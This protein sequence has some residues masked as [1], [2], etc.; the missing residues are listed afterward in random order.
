MAF[1]KFAL[2]M[3]ISLFANALFSKNIDINLQNFKSIHQIQANEFKNIQPS[4]LKSEQ[5]YK[6]YAKGEV[7]TPRV[8]KQVLGYYTYWKTGTA[9]IQ[10]DLLTILA[11][12]SAE[13]DSSGNITDLNGWPSS[14]PIN[15]AHAH[16]VKVILTATLFG[17]DSIRT[18]IQSE[19]N[20]QNCIQ[21]LFNQV[22]SAGADGICIDFELPYSSDRDYFNTFIQELADYFH[23]NMPGSLV[24]VDTPAVNWNDRMDFNTLTDYA[25]YLFIMAYDYHYSGGDPG[26]VSP[27]SYTSGSPWPTWAGIVQ[28]LDDYINGT[29]GVGNAK[30]SKLIL[31]VP[32][33]GYDW[34]A[35]DCTIP[36]TQRANASAV[37][38]SSAVD[39]AAQYN[40]EWDNYSQTP[41]YDYNCST[42][43]P[44]QAWYDDDISLGLKYDKV[45]EYG[46][47]GTGMWA[48]N[49]D[50]TRPELWQKL[51]EKFGFSYITATAYGNGTIS[52]SGKIQVDY[53]KNITFNFSPQAGY[54]I[55]DV[56]VDGTSV[57][58]VNSY[59][60]EN[61]V[62]DHTIEVY[63]EQDTPIT[64]T[65]T[66]TAGTGGTIE[67]SGNITANEGESIS[68]S[69]TPS[70]GY[71]IDRVLVDG[72]NVGA[73]STYTFNNINSNHTI[74]AYFKET[75]PETFTITA[76]A[77][78]GGII[79]PSGGI[80]VTKGENITFSIKPDPGFNID[81]VLIDGVNIGVVNSYTFE[82]VN[83]NHTIEAYFIENQSNV[84]TITASAGTGG[85]IDPSGEVKVGDGEN[86]T[87]VITP[88]TNYRIKEV[89]ID[90]NSVGIVNSYTFNNVQ[91]NHTIEAFFTELSNNKYSIK[92]DCGEGG[93]IFP[94]GELVVN[95]G[96]TKTFRITPD[97]GYIIDKVVVDGTN[98]G[99]LSTYTFKNINAN[100]T[101]YA[102]FTE[103]SV[104]EVEYFSAST[105]TGLTAL[106]VDFS[107]KFNE[108]NNRA[109]TKYY[110]IVSGDYEGS[111]ETEEPN[112]SLI[113]YA[114]G[115]YYIKVEA[116]NELGL[117]GESNFIRILPVELKNYP[118]SINGNYN[119]N[120]R[121]I[122]LNSHIVNP[123]NNTVRA[124]IKKLDGDNIIETKNITIEPY[125]KIK[126][127]DLFNNENN[128]ETYQ[129]TITPNSFVL[130]YTDISSENLGAAAYQGL[131]TEWVLNIPHIA[132]ETNYW[133]TIAS[134]GNKNAKNLIVTV[135]NNGSSIEAKY[136]N[137]INL[138]KLAENTPESFC[139]GTVY[140]IN[141]SQVLN[142][143]ELFVQN[144]ND[145][146]AISLSSKATNKFY[147]PHIPEEK[148]IFWTGFTFSNTENKE[149]KIVFYLYNDSKELIGTKTI[150]IAPLSKVK[151]L[152]EQL[153]DNEELQNAVW[154]YAVSSVKIT[155]IEIY[156]VSGGAICG[157]PL[158]S[159]E[160]EIGI[161]PIAQSD[162]NYWT[163]IIALN[164][165]T[166]NAF[167]T[168]KLYDGKGNEINEKQIKIEPF[169]RYKSLIGDLFPENRINENYFIQYFS[170]KPLICIEVEGDKTRTFMKALNAY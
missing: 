24:V 76:T 100:H 122:T 58:T 52:P 168:F 13:L 53:G 36:T 164:P 125:N 29:Y 65:I 93:S 35:Q 129:Y 147:I 160:K 154:G 105:Q 9:N 79:S 90:G 152:F 18:L 74:E 143:F 22:Q 60:F 109:I 138:N 155:G 121:E 69:I 117:K 64:Y 42:S 132:E 140:D 25:D 78:N 15:E 8:K 43:Y 141:Q 33:Y 170:S 108:P 10:W 134:I 139:W 37:I 47:G 110:W 124:S 2:L 6:L 81:R 38:Y 72:N 130:I 151:G 61:V 31:G 54:H 156:G 116:E 19:T 84:Y 71:A 27:L 66:A 118:L 115:T 123:L 131:T 144:N 127:S 162:E 165:N 114:A 145:G 20:R 82:N 14:A 119:L 17:Y 104:P 146:A 95:E 57:G 92:S 87:F 1:K 51:R 106:T 77:Y 91:A 137:L 40:R 11:Y 159:K 103:V 167:V 39:K 75:Q 21:N 150:D 89:L 158:P 96:E 5:Y 44:H 7:S 102:Y 28:T 133:D 55:S 48:L 62:Q 4:P 56:V 46:I 86:I 107:C 148:D 163:G 135:N 68:F 97:N 73:V 120:G 16:G 67:P 126:I 112:I 149:G 153:F 88:N 128:K 169:M 113:F 45:N 63:F 49:Y 161:L 99:R 41:F 26:P 59:T 34:P 157:Y 166:E 12:F 101:I 3:L 98:V 23:T 30:K 70:I 50:G 83:D 142:G 94:K 32:Y 85:A 136:C 80:K 111:F